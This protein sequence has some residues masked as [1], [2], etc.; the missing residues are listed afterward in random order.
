[1]VPEYT[2]KVY[3]TGPPKEILECADM[4]YMMIPAYYRKIL[5]VENLTI[6][7]GGTISIDWQHRKDFVSIEIG[8]GRVGFYSELP[9]G[10]NPEGVF[11]LT[12]ECPTAIIKAL[13]MLHGRKS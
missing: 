5:S 9:D 4:F 6:N 8:L 13:D 3:A 7:N 2:E 12:G 1:M 10:S 11:T